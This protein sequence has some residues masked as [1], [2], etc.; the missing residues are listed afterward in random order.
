MK[1]A[2]FPLNIFLLPGEQTCLHIFEDRYKQLLRD[3]EETNMPFGVYFQNKNNTSSFGSMVKLIDVNRRYNGGEIDITIEATYLFRLDTFYSNFDNKA[4]SGG[5]ISKLEEKV[6]VEL[7]SSI[8]D[9]FVSLVKLRNP[10]KLVEIPRNIWD[11]AFWLNL[12]S[13][14]KLELVRFSSI[15]S[16][17][18]FIKS[19]ILLNMAIL[20]QE[21]NAEFNMYLN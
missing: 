2:I 3:I 18:E 1:Y 16:Q 15:K 9:A 21:K 5:N 12:T 7:E 6:N 20:D 17:Q 11:V 10:G 4:Y 13:K 19:H 14:D 8:F